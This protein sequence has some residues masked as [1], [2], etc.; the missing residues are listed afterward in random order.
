[1]KQQFVKYFSLLLLLHQSL[2]LCAQ[3]QHAVDSIQN[4]IKSTHNDTIKI[5]ALIKLS[6]QCKQDNSKQAFDYGLQALTLAIKLNH[7]KSIG[8][9]HNNLGDVYWYKNDLGSSSYHY[10]KALKIFENLKDKA[11]IAYSYRNIGWI[12]DSQNNYNEAL[13]YYTKALTINQNLNKQK[14][15]GHNYNDIGIIYTKLKKFDYAT[16]NY[17]SA[18]K[19]QERIGN[20]REMAAI[21]SNLSL[22]YDKMRKPGIAIQ[23]LEKAIKISKEIG[24]KEYLSVVYCKLGEHYI[25][26]K[27]YDEAAANFKKA[28]KFAKEIGYHNTI[29]EAYGNF[30]VLYEKQND[31]RNAFEYA[32]LSSAL[33]DTIYNE[34]KNRQ[35]I[36][37]STKYESEKKELM[38]NSLEKDKER[39]K[40]FRTYLI[41]F[42]V[43]IA[44]FAFVLF[45][46]NIQKR[47]ANLALSFAYEEIELK[48][49]DITDSINYAK[50]IQRAML[51]YRKDIWAA[52]PQSF[53]LFKPK[54]IVSGDFYFFHKNNESVFIAVADCTGHGVPGAFMSMIGAGKLNEAVSLSS[55]TSEILSLLNKGIK[56][57]L[58]QSDSDESTRDGMDIALCSVDT[59]NRIVKYAGANCPL[60]LI[61]NGQ[62]EVE[63][64]KATKRAIGGLTEDNQQFESHELKLQLGDTFYIFTDGY[65]DQFGGAK[66]KKLMTKKLKE[67]LLEIQSKT[68]KEQKQCLV[69][70]VENWKAGTEQVD[71]ILIIGIRV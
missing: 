22:V 14:E 23:S 36:E 57:A 18:L 27:K 12:Y 43:L 37:M 69:N 8:D 15:L 40:K 53:V 9:A 35:A 70:F 49:K 21:Y 11:A 64:I 44:V 25:N 51:P 5:A 62:T 28:L 16:K 60:W 32:Q 39:E 1:M 17:L 46:G 24:D 48:N 67:M 54:D 68:M 65:A 66:G 29:Q 61:R 63:E 7:P 31:F 47:K 45:R 55:D 6:N 20:K 26:S 10:F 71:D 42:M 33:K 38:I 50:R 56:T 3:E 34:S 30:I 13:N 4:L 58:K 59:E 41:L 52:F 19:I 2:C